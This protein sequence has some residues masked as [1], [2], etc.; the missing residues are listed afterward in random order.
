MT[1]PK[2]SVIKRRL[3]PQIAAFSIHRP[4]TAVYRVYGRA[5]RFIA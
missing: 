2:Q 3:P 5:R 4:I 1:K